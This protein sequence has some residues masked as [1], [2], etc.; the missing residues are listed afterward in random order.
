MRNKRG[1][2][3]AHFFIMEAE[4]KELKQ[5]LSA[6]CASAM[7]VHTPEFEPVCLRIA[8]RLRAA[9]TQGLTK[10]VIRVEM[11][12]TKD[13]TFHLYATY[14]F[15]KRGV[16]ICAYGG[17]GPSERVPGIS[18]GKGRMSIDKLFLFSWYW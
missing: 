7:E 9:A 15:R 5:E 14:W 2:S 8:E 12:V 6:L 18:P 4:H 13:T 1:L 3:K 10:K 16:E 17:S 11:P